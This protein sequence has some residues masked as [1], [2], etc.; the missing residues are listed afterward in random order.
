VQLP[1]H[2]LTDPVRTEL[3]AVQA[4]V[5]VD[6]GE[7]GTR[8]GRMAVHGNITPTRQKAPAQRCRRNVDCLTEV[9][10]DRLLCA[11]AWS[12]S[13]YSQ[14]PVA[15][16]VPVLDTLNLRHDDTPT[17]LH[18]GGY[19]RTHPPTHVRIR[20]NRNDV[21]AAQTVVEGARSGLWNRSDKQK[22]DA[23]ESSEVLIACR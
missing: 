6:V 2:S 22:E 8:Q 5:K 14:G 4:H 1:R 23:K 12:H 21:E 9:P 13:N 19:A 3:A 11:P 17:R 10:S 20:L 16:R 7:G 18:K 15:G